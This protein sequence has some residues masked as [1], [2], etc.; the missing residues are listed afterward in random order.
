MLVKSFKA[1]S[2]YGYLD[3]DIKF[4]KDVSFLIGGNG[5]GKT[6]AL[7]LM[8]ALL[9]PKLHELLLIPFSEAEL[10]ISK[11]NKEIKISAALNRE[12]IELNVSTVNDSLLL[13]ITFFEDIN[14]YAS[15]S[16]R[17]Q[18]AVDD[19]NRNFTDHPTYKEIIALDSPVFLGLDRK[20]ENTTVQDEKY[21]IE[22]ERYLRISKKYAAA[23]KRMFDGSIGA[24]LMDTEL[25][26]QT[27]YRRIR[28]LE[29]KYSS[30]LR[31]KILMSSFK[32]TSVNSSTISTLEPDVKK[33]KGDEKQGLLERK[34]EIQEA[35]S[36]IGGNESSLS[37]QVDMFFEEI[38][39]LFEELEETSEKFSL[40][41]LLNKAQIERMSDIV[42]IIDEHKSKV[43]QLYRPIDKFLS[44]VNSFFKDSRKKLKIDAVGGILVERPS[45]SDCSIDGLSS[46]ER[47]LV[48]IFAHALFNSNTNAKTA[49][50]ID[51]PELSLHL[52]WQEKFAET[53]FSISPDTQFILATHSPEI[54]GSH[55]EKVIKCR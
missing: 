28:E 3:F 51:E 48:V 2:V 25:L 13:P 9:F 33:W 49:F 19:I 54:V 17:F 53:I 7:K 35:V 26:V 44:T 6:T 31:D 21:Y 18:K 32:Y 43:D 22:R 46:G 16:D 55:K 30:R 38:T 45:G 47:Q 50:I 5:S 24:S 41:W 40:E 11:K 8:N 36:N 1:K 42:D 15:G 20:R 27:A 23:P 39:R 29:S 34:K 12:S 4:N 10:L 52:G 14:Y 37:K